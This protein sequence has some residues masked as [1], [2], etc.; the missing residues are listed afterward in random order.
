MFR[1]HASLERHGAHAALCQDI[2]LAGFAPRRAAFATLARAAMEHA[3]A[4][5]RAWRR[6]H[7]IA[8]TVRALRRV[9]DATLRD[10]GVD[11]SGI[12]AA[13][14]LAVDGICRDGRAATRRPTGGGR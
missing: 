14:A 8:R 2:S 1:N 10:I 9:D 12:R 5:V 4:R 3:R 7:A 11:R 6:E 13:A